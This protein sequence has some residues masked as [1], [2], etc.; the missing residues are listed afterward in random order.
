[1][2]RTTTN[3]VESML[4]VA[5]HPAFLVLVALLLAPLIVAFPALQLLAAGFLLGVIR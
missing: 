1:M 3:L 5:Q 2:T 4:S